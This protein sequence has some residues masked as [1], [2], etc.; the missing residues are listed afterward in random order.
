VVAPTTIFSAPRSLTRF[1]ARRRAAVAI[2]CQPS[3]IF[4]RYVADDFLRLY[5]LPLTASY[6]QSQGRR[7]DAPRIVMRF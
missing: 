7:Q 2:I 6:A 3:N 4:T 1:A 5:S